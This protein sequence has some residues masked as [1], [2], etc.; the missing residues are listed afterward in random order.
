MNTDPKETPSPAEQA[1][2]DALRANEFQKAINIIVNN[3]L[4][5]VEEKPS[6]KTQPPDEDA[7][8]AARTWDALDESERLSIYIIGV[9][10]LKHWFTRVMLHEDKSTFNLL[11]DIAKAVREAIPHLDMTAIERLH[12][13]K[14]E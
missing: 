7:I 3:Y 14:P 8:T 2:L 10:G 4:P 9:L 11:E 13:G 6:I 12:E 5:P 1:L